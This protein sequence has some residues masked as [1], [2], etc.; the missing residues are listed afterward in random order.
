MDNTRWT[1]VGLL[2][3]ALVA[4]IVGVILQLW[5]NTERL[6]EESADATR[7]VLDQTIV[8]I[9]A[10]SE[11]IPSPTPF[12]PQATA[13]PPPS[14]FDSL[15]EVANGWPLFA[16]E[17]FDNNLRGWSV[18]ERGTYSLGTR[19]I[20]D[21]RYQ[22]ELTAIEGFVWWTAPIGVPFDNFYASVIV[23]KQLRDAGDTSIVFRY[24]DG[25]NYYE[26]GLCD[27][28][29]QYRVYKE[30][31]GTRTAVVNCADHPAINSAERNTLAVLA[32]GSR[33]LLFI[34]GQ[35]AN[36]LND[37]DH[38]GGSVGVG[39]DMDEGQANL[40]EFDDLV[41]RSADIDR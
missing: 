23:D 14:N 10:T 1:L 31:E 24:D 25:D 28:V 8:A 16:Y 9:T 12:V 30:T 41:V 18:G 35:Y 38:T 2:F 33:Y 20:A 32:Q 13:E 21:G 39:L 7:I 6:S 11:L 15:L 34:N 17:P 5:W 19:S 37:D 36:T 22:W 3:S 26:F 29:N 27:D 4:I 40:I